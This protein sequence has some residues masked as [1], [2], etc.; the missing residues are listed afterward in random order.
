TIMGVYQAQVEALV[1]YEPQASDLKVTLIKADGGFPQVLRD[2][3]HVEL[4][5]DSPANGWERVAMGSFNVVN[6]PGDHF[7]M[8]VPPA[9]TTLANAVRDAIAQVP[10]PPPPPAAHVESSIHINPMHP[11]FLADPYP[12]YAL[13]RD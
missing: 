6:V 13:L 7:N 2:D 1:R 8:L 10:P 3:R 4:F 11:D 12:F 9:L 5:F